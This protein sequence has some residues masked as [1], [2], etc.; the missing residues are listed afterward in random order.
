[1]FDL[2]QGLSY[3]S[4]SGS[5]WTFNSQT[6]TCTQNSVLAPGAAYPQ[7]VLKVNVSDDAPNSADTSVTVSGGGSASST[8]T[9]F[10]SIINQSV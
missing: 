3:E 4:F 7:I 9:N 1:V 2:P 5:G 6:L 10:T 8:S